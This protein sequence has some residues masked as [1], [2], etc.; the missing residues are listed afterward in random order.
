MTAIAFI[1]T[2]NRCR[3]LMAH[4]IFVEEARRRSLAVDIYS[5][6]V[7][8]FS[9]QPPL[10]ETSNTC[11]HF[12][13][14]PPKQTPTWVPQ[15]PLDSITRFLVMETG[16]AD[17]LMREFGISPNRV[18]L[19]GAFDPQKRGAEIADP[20][21]SH[22]ELVYQR[23]YEQIRD[24]IIGYLDTADELRSATVTRPTP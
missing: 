19:L 22:S 1:C 24:C 2:A 7:V 14:P 17:A 15:L 4:A 9:D 6:G 10:I 3:S 21:F 11:L 8:D 20:F 18:S 12:N 5:A 16:H 23:S 13:T